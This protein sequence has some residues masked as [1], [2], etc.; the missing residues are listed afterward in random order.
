M[1]NR[2]EPA[3]VAATV[4]DAVVLGFDDD[5]FQCAGLSQFKEHTQKSALLLDIA[6]KHRHAATLVQGT[7]LLHHAVIHCLDKALP[8]RD[9]GEVKTARVVPIPLLYLRGPV[10]DIRIL[11]DIPV[12]RVPE[13]ELRPLRD[14]A[15]QQVKPAMQ[16]VGV[17]VDAHGTGSVA[18]GVAAAHIVADLLN[19][20]MG[21][22]IL[23]QFRGAVAAVLI[24]ATLAALRVGY[25]C[26]QC[27]SLVRHHSR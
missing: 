26:S 15:V 2:D 6:H 24:I 4:G 12:R 27:V 11:D 14:I 7:E 25:D 19:T 22:Q 21:N 20:K 23:N 5:I 17:A 9:P 10:H 8:G 13:D 1:D 18:G 3:A 16:V